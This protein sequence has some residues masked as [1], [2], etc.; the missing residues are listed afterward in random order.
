MEP[1]N[2]DFSGRGVKI[3]EGC[4]LDILP[5]LPEG[6]CHMTACSPPYY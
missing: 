5:R 6:S 3:L 2:L 1:I 4:V